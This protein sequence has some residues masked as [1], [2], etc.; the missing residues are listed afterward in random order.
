MKPRL[1]LLIENGM[2]VVA[3]G[4]GFARQRIPQPSSYHDFADRRAFFGVANFLDVVSN[5]A[6]LLVGIWGLFVVFDSKFGASPL[7]SAERWSY[8]VLF[9]GFVLTFVGSSYYHLQPT[10]VRLVW[11]RLPMTLGFMGILSATI[12]ERISM[13]AGIW[14]LLPLIIVG[15]WS[16]VYWYRTE[17]RGL[18]DLRPYYVVQ[19]GSLV[20]VLAMVAL[21]RPRYTLGWCLVL[22]LMLYAAAKFAEVFDSQIYRVTQAVS[23]HTVKH[24]TA[25]A[26]GLVIALMLQ[27]RTALKVDVS[28]L[29]TPQSS[30]PSKM[31]TS[32]PR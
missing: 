22:A 4:L 18:G 27:N 31:M 24:F 6:F 15:L 21:C 3:G 26:A 9:S 20:S 28:E 13:R 19:F 17:I 7:P 16:V 32:S 2:A 8:I 29:S 11:D 1:L 25:A 10:N 12:A 14:L 30:S 5:V 23:G